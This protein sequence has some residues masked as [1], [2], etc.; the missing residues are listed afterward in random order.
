MHKENNVQTVTIVIKERNLYYEV[1]PLIFPPT[2][3]WRLTP[4]Q[5]APTTPPPRPPAPST[6][7][8]TPGT[9]SA[10][11][12]RLSRWIGSSGRP[13]SPREPEGPRQ[14]GDMRPP[15][16]GPH[17]D[18]GSRLG[19]IRWLTGRGSSRLRNTGPGTGRF[20]HLD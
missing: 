1:S 16:A 10:P 20:A 4:T 18:T 19:A 17:Q 12:P 5:Q 2:G 15:W 6:P 9:T 7:P 13:T 14:Q 3:Q 8:T 11:Q